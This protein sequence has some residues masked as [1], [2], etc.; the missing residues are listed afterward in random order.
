MVEKNDNRNWNWNS[1]VMDW[2]NDPPALVDPFAVFHNSRSTLGFA[3]GHAE[4][5]VWKDPDTE[6]HSQSILAGGTNF[7]FWESDNVDLNW[8]ELHY[9]KK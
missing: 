3:D 6:K 2:S 5:I 1:W 9:P 4:R 7:Y 8:L